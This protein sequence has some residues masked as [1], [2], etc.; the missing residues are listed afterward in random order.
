MR[1]HEEAR[2]FCLK[3]GERA[4]RLL[5]NAGVGGLV[6]AALRGSVMELICGQE[7]MRK[8][9]AILREQIR[10][11]DEALAKRGQL[12]K[13]IQRVMIDVRDTCPGFVFDE[14]FRASIKDIY[15]VLRE[16]K[17]AAIREAR[18]VS[19]GVS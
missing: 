8:E 3:Y 16:T 12:L 1:T 6:P 11:R 13:V 4:D 18:K 19:D 7:E 2:A 15:V 9:I 5:V 17:V 10:R 14:H